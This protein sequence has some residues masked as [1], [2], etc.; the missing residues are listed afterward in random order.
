MWTQTLFLSKLILLLIRSLLYTLNQ[1]Y[2]KGRI[3]YKRTLQT[4]QTYITVK[5]VSV[6]WTDLEAN[7]KNSLTQL[8][9]H[10]S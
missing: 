1:F 8:F 7:I 3:Y 6:S 5:Y 4:I 2:Y 9:N 10:V